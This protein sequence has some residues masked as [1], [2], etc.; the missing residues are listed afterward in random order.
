MSKQKSVESWDNYTLD[1]NNITEG[2]ELI[3]RYL[4]E[5]RLKKNNDEAI[6]IT[7]T[8]LYFNKDEKKWCID[9]LEYEP[10]FR[11]KHLGKTIAYFVRLEG[12]DT[13]LDFL[14]GPDDLKITVDN[15][16]TANMVFRNRRWTDYLPVH[17][18]R[19]C[20]RS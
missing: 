12:V 18:I 6:I 4:L 19:R 14:D 5:D 16:S 13:I 20:F 1:L 11:D 8:V 3:A 7:D 2:G 9:S 17:T 15:N 10:I